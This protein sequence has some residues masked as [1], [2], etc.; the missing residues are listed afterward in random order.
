MTARGRRFL[1]RVVTALVALVGLVTVGALPAAARTVGVGQY[2]ALG[3][4]YA[5]GEGGGA[6]SYLD[7]CLRSTNGYPALLD[8]ERQIHL[9]AEPACTGATTSDVR[10]DQLLALKPS[11]RLVTLTVGANDL[12]LSTVLTACT[13]G[14]PAQCAQAIGSARAL[15]PPTC[16]GD[17]TLG[18]RLEALYADVAASAPHARIVV[19][20][21]P[22]LFELVPGDPQLDLK[23][24]IDAATT[25]LNCAIAKAVTDAQTSGT[26]IVFVDPT[27]AF[28]G[29]GIGGT[30]VPF[31]NPPGTGAEAFHPTAAGY[32]AYAAQI[33]DA[34]PSSWSHSQKASGR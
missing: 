25:L 27:S 7:P 5:A 2:V 16:G 21:Y 24:Q 29:H 12:G 22:L 26:D 6:G 18:K 9:R 14:S 15:L 19:T 1:T 34:L 8:A 13:A 32:V 11:T 3:D 4:S 20:G 33:S 17:S 10:R 28:A 23:G 31:I 30:G